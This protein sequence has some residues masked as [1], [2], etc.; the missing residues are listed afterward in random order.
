MTTTAFVKFMAEN[1]DYSQ[2]VIHEFLKDFEVARAAYIEKM[3]AGETVKITDVNYKVAHVEE[4]SGVS[5]MLGKEWT[6]PAHDVV[7]VSITKA[8]K[9][10]KDK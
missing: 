3:E 2:K 10:I 4:R 6:K 8:I 1:S 9:K 5:A 7:R